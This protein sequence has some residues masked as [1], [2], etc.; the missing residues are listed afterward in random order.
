MNPGVENKAFF[1]FCLFFLLFFKGRGVCVT[2]QVT[3]FAED[4]LNMYQ[5]ARPFTT[6]KLHDKQQGFIC[7]NDKCTSCIALSEAGKWNAA[8]AF[9][10]VFHFCALKIKLWNLLE[11]GT[12]DVIFPQSCRHFSHIHLVSI[13]IM[14]WSEAGET[15]KVTT[16][17]LCQSLSCWPIR[18]IRSSLAR[19]ARAILCFR[20]QSDL[21]LH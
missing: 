4:F 7:S 6:T 10:G 20:N 3:V 1:G 13:F 14:S 21:S 12:P 17:N 18:I 11:D 8:T 19:L 15:W 2:Q 5:P 16:T 9:F